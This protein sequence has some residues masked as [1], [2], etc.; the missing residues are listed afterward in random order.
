MSLDKEFKWQADGAFTYDL[1]K[2]DI[3]AGFQAGLTGGLEACNRN[4]STL[5]KQISELR[6][7][8]AMIPLFRAVGVDSGV[9]CLKLI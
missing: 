9:E 3:D 1:A 4:F 6:S 7:T 8:S 2:Q 5:I